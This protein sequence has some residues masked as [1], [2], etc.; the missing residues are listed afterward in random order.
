MRVKQQAARRRSSLRAG[1]HFP[2]AGRTAGR[3]TTATWRTTKRARQAPLGVQALPPLGARAGARAAQGAAAVRC[4]RL[5]RPRLPASPASARDPL[6]RGSAAAALRPVVRH[7]SRSR[8]M[9]FLL[10]PASAR[11]QPF[12]AAACGLLLLLL[13]L[14]PPP[15]RTAGS[16]GAA[17]HARCYQV[18]LQAW[19]GHWWR[20]LLQGAGGRVLACLDDSSAHQAVFRIFAGC[21]W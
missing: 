18:G 8:R 5:P 1:P 17:G 12:A 19:T 10:S 16:S 21:Q 3:G 13:L 4:P 15:P 6:G 7:V 2:S 9:H 11:E 14:P 20:L